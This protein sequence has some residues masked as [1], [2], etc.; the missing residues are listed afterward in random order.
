MSRYTIQ[1]AGERFY[2]FVGEHDGTWLSSHSSHREAK[3]AVKRY[4][5]GDARRA[6]TT[7]EAT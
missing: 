1:K 4:E 3:K 5:A 7:K 6:R 2:V